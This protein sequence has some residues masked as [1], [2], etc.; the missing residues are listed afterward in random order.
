MTYHLMAE[1]GRVVTDLPLI[2]EL[3]EPHR[4]GLGPGFIGYRAHCYR[5][6]NWARF[7]SEDS[8]HRDD[9]LAIMTVFHDLPF[10]TSGDLDYLDSACEWADGHLDDIGRP[11]WKEEM[12]L[13][14]SNHHKVRSYTGPHADLVNATRKADWIDVTFTKVTYGIPRHLI[15]E[16][17]ATFPMNEAY[18][19][20]AMPG[21][22]RYARRNLRRPLPMMRW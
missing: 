3:L 16:V 9:R 11:E 10:F 14:I 22:A 19:A 5:M 18:K 4:K 13:M 6:V 1:T 21:I 2:D 17:R 7:L 8:P 12:R 15:K 20:V